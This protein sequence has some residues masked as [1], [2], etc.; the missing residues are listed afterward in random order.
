MPNLKLMDII[1]GPFTNLNYGAILDAIY[2][3]KYHHVLDVWF[4]RNYYPAS[5]NYVM[6][7][8]IP[9]LLLEPIHF[10]YYF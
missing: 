10:N 6:H 3:T 5:H 2:S 9:E 8:S 4:V 7:A 1:D